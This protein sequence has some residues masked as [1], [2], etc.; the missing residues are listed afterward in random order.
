LDSGCFSD[1]DPLY[2]SVSAEIEEI[3]RRQQERNVMRRALSLAAVF[4]CFAVAAVF[5]HHGPMKV[6]ITGAAEK[7]QPPVTFDHHKHAT[8]L[9]DSCDTCHH[10]MEGLT[11]KTDAD[12]K[13]CAS[14]HL[15]SSSDAPSMAAAGLKQNPFHVLC[16]NCHREEKQGP[17]ACRDCH[18]KS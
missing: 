12:V 18:V 6:T 3:C 13:K 7:K 10:T 11:A 4:V 9:V 2:G 1:Y 15:D 16:I 5:A 8:S 14:C 17:T